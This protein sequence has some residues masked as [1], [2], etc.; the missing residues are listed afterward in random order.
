MFL[1]SLRKR[2]KDSYFIDG[3]NTTKAGIIEY[4]FKNQPHY[5]LNDEIDKMSPKDQ[6]FLLNL[7]ETGIITE[8]KYGKTRKQN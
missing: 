6:A 7:M 4:L 3:G 2:Q 1:L 8:T 5:L